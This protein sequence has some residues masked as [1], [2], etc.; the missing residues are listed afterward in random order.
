MRVLISLAFALVGFLHCVPVFANNL[1]E[2]TL[3]ESAI[4]TSNRVYLSDVAQ[5]KATLPEIEYTAKKALITLI[6]ER[7]KSKIITK[8]GIQRIVERQIPSLQGKI[9]YLG[10]QI[11]VINFFSATILAKDKSLSTQ[12]PIFTISRGEKVKLKINT[13]L[14][15][16]EDYAI[17]LQNGKIGEK[18]RLKNIKNNEIID[19][20]VTENGYVEIQ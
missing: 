3:N 16:I 11:C 13:G 10:A 8:K 1:L 15:S 7:E 6:T 4:V 12:A 17:A 18:I 5:V 9:E 2:V 19:G 14:I 20:V